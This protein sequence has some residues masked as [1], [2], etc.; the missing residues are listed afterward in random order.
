MIV[1]LSATHLLS[2]NYAGRRLDVILEQ[3]PKNMTNLWPYLRL[4]MA[5]ASERRHAFKQ[6]FLGQYTSS[7]GYDPL[8]EHLWTSPDNNKQV[9]I[10]IRFV[11]R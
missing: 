5:E 6:S 8:S 2:R 11:T 3:H 7:M 4:R 9:D 10:A 1:Y